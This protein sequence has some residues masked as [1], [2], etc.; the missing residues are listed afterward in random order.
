VT[1]SDYPEV[2]AMRVHDAVWLP[3]DNV[4]ARRILADA[5]AVGLTVTYDDGSQIVFARLAREKDD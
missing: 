4:A 5:D 1:I 3:S 2:M